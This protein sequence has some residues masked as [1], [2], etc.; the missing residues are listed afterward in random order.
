MSS[1]F[2]LFFSFFQTHSF[3]FPSFLL[4]FSIFLP[5]YLST[6]LLSIFLA[7]NQLSIFLSICLPLFL[8]L[9]NELID[10]YRRATALHVFGLRATFLG[11]S[12][13]AARGGHPPRRPG[14]GI[15]SPRSA[16]DKGGGRRGCPTMCQ[17]AAG[18][19]GARRFLPS[20]FTTAFEVHLFNLVLVH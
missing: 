12:E 16:L 11:I 10:T 1:F 15:E 4:S 13:A 8:C 6:S 14:P 20:H 3:V 5:I 9:P 19:P 2:Y 17:S 7:S 18:V